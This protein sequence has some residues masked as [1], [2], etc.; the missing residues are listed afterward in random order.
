MP[1]A[2]EDS[3][4]NVRVLIADD[5]RDLREIFAAWLRKLGC[6]VTEVADGQEALEALE[7]EHFDAIVTDV[8]M[9][10]VT[11]IELVH[12][13][14]ESARYTP[15]IIFVSGFVD[16]PLPD[17]YDLGIEAVLSKPCHRKDLTSAL[18]RSIQRRNLIFEP[19]DGVS[20]PDERDYIHH[21]RQH[22]D[23][24][25]VALGRGGVSL[26]VPLSIDPGISVGFSL[27]LYGQDLNW[28]LCGWG[29]VRWCELIG[30]QI[31]A[32]IEFMHLDEASRQS[33]ARWL[34]KEHPPSFIPKAQQ[35]KI[36]SRSSPG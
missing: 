2:A 13:L 20:A 31:R 12:S 23:A 30:E 32:G 9:P 8:R 22:A 6:D 14:R 36:A 18:R 35:A 27:E 5:E 28:T 34:A 11:G 10:R 16:L 33:F 29:V 26:G 3:L 19:A 24:E 25:P 17:A 4:K 7:R 21:D 15:V 1:Q